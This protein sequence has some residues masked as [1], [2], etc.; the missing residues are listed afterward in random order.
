VARRSGATPAGN[1]RRTRFDPTRFGTVKRDGNERW[2][3]LV[4]AAV[5][6][7]HDKG[8]TATSI[9]DLADAAGIT[10]GSVYH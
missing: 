1:G 4:G 2:E 8:Y 7:F 6:L 10:K 9:Q 3:L 5:Q